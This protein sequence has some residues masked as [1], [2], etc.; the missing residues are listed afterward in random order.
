MY[1]VARIILSLMLAYT[2][3]TTREV[4]PDAVAA[5]LTITD[6]GAPS[7]M[8]ATVAGHCQNT[9]VGQPGHWTA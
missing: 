3:S 6:S 9:P 4:S 8:M 2:M 5:S 7:A 1:R